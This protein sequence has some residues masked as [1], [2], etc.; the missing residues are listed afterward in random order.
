[1]KNFSLKNVETPLYY[2]INIRVKYLKTHKS[3]LCEYI[4]IRKYNFK[5]PLH[6]S[7]LNER[8]KNINLKIIHKNS[9]NKDNLR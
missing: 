5:F 7:I 2:I 4:F 1:M 3:I 9:D 8:I 6:D